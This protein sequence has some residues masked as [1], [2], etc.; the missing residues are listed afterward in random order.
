MTAD[1]E[2]FSRIT[3]KVQHS[4]QGGFVPDAALD[5]YAKFDGE[6]GNG[7]Q[8]YGGRRRIASR[9]RS[10]APTGPDTAGFAFPL[11]DHKLRACRQEFVI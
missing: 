2:A 8:T 4:G 6:F 1:C 11:T 3:H 10:L 5:P 9:C 7:S